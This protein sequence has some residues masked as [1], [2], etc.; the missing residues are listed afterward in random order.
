MLAVQIG[1]LTP[2]LGLGSDERESRTRSKKPPAS[3]TTTSQVFF[4]KWTRVHGFRTIL[5][6]SGIPEIMTKINGVL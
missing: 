4:S 6:L 1:P 5:Q 3:N 2:T